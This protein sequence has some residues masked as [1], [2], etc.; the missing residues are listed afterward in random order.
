MRIGAVQ[1][2]VTSS[3]PLNLSKILSFI[4]SPTCTSSILLFP[5]C[6]L[7][8]YTKEAVETQIHLVN[9]AVVDIG[10]ACRENK[11]AVIVGT[12]ITNE[13]GELGSVKG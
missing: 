1:M 4:T 13:K 12:A 7:T 8:G 11:R 10:V 3:L 5:E 6:A 2:H 9:D